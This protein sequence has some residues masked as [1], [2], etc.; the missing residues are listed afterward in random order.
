MG[1]I[2]QLGGIGDVAILLIWLIVLLLVNS[3]I[4]HKIVRIFTAL[5]S[6]LFIVIQTLSL[7]FT[8]SF[9]GYQFYLHAN[10]NGVVG[11]QSLF[12]MQIILAV[13]AV[14]L[15][16]FLFYQSPKI[17]KA[18]KS[19]KLIKALGIVVL[20][21]IVFFQG[22]FAADTKTLLPVLTSDSKKG[23]KEVLAKNNMSDYVTPDEI[24]CLAGK[25]IIIIS[26]ESLERGF[27][28]EKYASI[29]PNLNKLK[30]QWNYLDVQQNNGSEW[31]SGSLYTYL[32]GFPAF[33]GVHGNSIFQTAYHSDISSIS[34][35][36]KKLNY[37]TTYIN[38][39]TD[40][41]GTKEMLNALQFEKIIDYRNSP[42]KESN[43]GNGI[44]DKELFSIAKLELAKLQKDKK[45]FSLFISTTDTHFP[46]GIYDKRM[47]LVIPPQKTD[48]EFTIATLDY[49][50]GDFIAYLKKN[51]L[52]KNTAIFIFPD[53]LKM[54]DPEPLN[55][56]GERALYLITN[57]QNIAPNEDE[58]YQIDLAKMILEGAEIKH[59]LKFLTDYI[60]G[61]KQK[62][63]QNNILGLTEINTNGFKTSNI[64]AFDINKISKNY[65]SYKKDTFRFIAH[66]GGKIDGHTY[67]NSL[68][69]LDHNYQKGFRLFE[70]D[71]IE[72]KDSQYVAAH[73]WEQWAK[74]TSY[75][76]ATPPSEEEFLQQKILGKYTPLN[77][78]AINRW[79]K[80]H[81]D[82]ILITDKV[83]TPKEF[84]EHFIDKSRLM[85]E[86]F[87]MESLEEGLKAGIRSAMPS[88][89]IIKKLKIENIASL[90][91]KGVK[92]IAISRRFIA[93]HKAIIEEFKKQKIKAFVYHINF[94]VGIDEDYVLKYELD[95]VYGLYADKW[96]F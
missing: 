35:V 90:V 43:H 47:E 82:A 10:M 93:P 30:S 79:F 1:F 17:L 52:L 6:S 58:L 29:T 19:F 18:L 51:N 65:D 41:S 5:I 13:L 28:A 74:I 68:E 50:V 85:M 91:Q 83:N 25:N 40:H 23:F 94:D 46:D 69:A 16:F 2:E 22:S 96:R 88:Q 54:G 12:V 57:A 56:T 80:E 14:G 86:L 62:Y 87:T 20:G 84:S 71:I 60:M 8:Q 67:T 77:M 75:K 61:N 15:L 37:Q 81:S 78:E 36:L 76:G 39:N 45:P 31:T 33:F 38:G 64:D 66:A 49:L 63:I 3:F 26:M 95:D 92:H 70:L 48:L 21:F 7:Y 27:L 42:L 24:E 89:S 73:D 55:N 44:R 59:N 32:T 9:V 72:T 34:H 53:H 11:M 4:S